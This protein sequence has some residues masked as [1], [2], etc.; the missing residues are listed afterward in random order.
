MRLGMVLALA[1]TAGCS[2]LDNTP[3]RASI[4]DNVNRPSA[5]VQGVG[6]E[7]QDIV[8]MTD[9]MARDLLNSPTFSDKSSVS[10][11]IVDSQYFVNEGS[12]RLNKN[13][14]TDRLRVG[15]N[16]AAQGRMLFIARE[17]SAMV[18]EERALKRDG[19]VDAGTLAPV[20]VRAG[21]D[22]RLTGRIASLN[23][24]D[25]GTG[26]RSQYSQITFEMVDLEYGSI[27]WSGIYEFKKSS[28]DDVIYR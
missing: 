10:R 20:K 13:L 26:A 8:A 3:G 25:R 24:V 5:T 12:S 6:V 7:S 22:Y 9:R 27:I 1:L 23:A 21:A 28:Q 11:V 16:R 14:I 4:Y 19:T 15:L 18:D 2:S 17:F